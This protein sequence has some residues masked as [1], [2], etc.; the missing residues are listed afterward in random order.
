MKAGSVALNETLVD[1]FKVLGR[2]LKEYAPKPEIQKVGTVSYIGA[3]VA[4]VTG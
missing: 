2:A 4:R 3:G 1:T